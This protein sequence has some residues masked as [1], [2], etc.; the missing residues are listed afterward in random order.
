[1]LPAAKTGWLRVFFRVWSDM[2]KSSSENRNKR[3]RGI[4]LNTQL[5]LCLASALCSAPTL[6]RQRPDQ[7]ASVFLIPSDVGKLLA[8]PLCSLTFSISPERLGSLVTVISNTCGTTHTH[9]YKHTHSHD[10]GWGC[11]HPKPHCSFSAWVQIAGLELNTEIVAMFAQKNT[12]IY[13]HILLSLFKLNKR[14]SSCL[15]H[16][17]C[18]DAS[19]GMWKKTTKNHPRM[20]VLKLLYPTITAKQKR[21]W[22]FFYLVLFWKIILTRKQDY[23]TSCE[24][25]KTLTRVF[26]GLYWFLLC[27]ELVIL[28]KIWR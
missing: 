10:K 24:Q 3:E 11:R 16:Q 5:W 26:I 7:P 15:E 23:A 2:S 27:H 13:T 12:N 21:R 20:S 6:W 1:M 4:L 18:K 8:S 19:Y 25:L 22:R 28:W 14:R 17:F 9:T